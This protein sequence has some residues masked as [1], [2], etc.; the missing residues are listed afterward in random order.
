M[1]SPSARQQPHHHHHPPPQAAPPDRQRDD[2][3]KEAKSS[4]A[5]AA[6]AQKTATA[7][8]VTRPTTTAPRAPA[9]SAEELAAVK[10]QK[11]CRVYLVIDPLFC[12]S[13]HHFVLP[14]SNGFMARDGLIWEHFNTRW[15]GRRSQRARGLDRLMLLLE[16]LAVKRQTYE[17]LYCMQT[18]TRVQTQIHSRRVKTEED[19]KA[20]KSQVHVKQS[21]DRIKVQ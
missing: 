11:A 1:T 18:M 20:L 4:D 5:A 3:I 16:G 12:C 2:G 7:T 14:I 21:L 6:A 8:A 10:I 19:K 13:F 15:Q 9:R 17:A